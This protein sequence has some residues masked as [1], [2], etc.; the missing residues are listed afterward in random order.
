VPLGWDLGAASTEG[1]TAGDRSIRWE[2]FRRTT[3]AAR[4]PEGFLSSA[5][6]LLTPGC[7]GDRLLLHERDKLGERL[8]R[9][10]ELVDE[11]DAPVVGAAFSLSCLIRM[12]IVP[13]SG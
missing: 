8:G 5:R 6:P 2:A 9:R 4:T 3:R 13:G 7:S 10:G 11:D 12:V 1:R